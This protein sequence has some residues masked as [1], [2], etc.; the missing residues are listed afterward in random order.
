MYVLIQ[1]M[2][3]NHEL[4][5][6]LRL[7]IEECCDGVEDRATPKVHL[8]GAIADAHRICPYHAAVQHKAYPMQIFKEGTNDEDLS[9]PTARRRSSKQT[10]WL[11]SSSWWRGCAVNPV[12]MR[13]VLHYYCLAR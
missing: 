3:F 8:Q 10:M 13:V 11:S 9:F 1:D 4:E 5:V 12:D 2:T 7:S 6:R